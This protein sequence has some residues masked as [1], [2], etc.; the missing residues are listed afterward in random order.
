[1]K[2][3]AILLTTLVLL[4]HCKISE[5]PEFIAVDNFRIL[6]ASE[7]ELVVSADA[8]FDNPND[9]GGTLKGENIKVYVNGIETANIVSEK[10]DVPANDKFSI[11]LIAN[12][13]TDSLFSDNGLGSLLGSVLAQKFKIRYQGDIIYEVMGF[14][15]TYAIDKTEDVK[16]KL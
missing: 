7:K 6:N 16:I 1:M 12:I 15:Y 4:T 9:I 3:F 14:S 5:K 10:F 2:K 11:P 13:P 8:H